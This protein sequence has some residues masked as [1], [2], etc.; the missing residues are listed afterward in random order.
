[1]NR[2][3]RVLGVLAMMSVL[4]VMGGKPAMA[5]DDH[6]SRGCQ[7]GRCY[8]HGE[9]HEGHDGRDWDDDH[10]GQS[11]YNNGQNNWGGCQYNGCYPRNDAYTQG[12][13]DG[14]RQGTVDGQQD[15]APRPGSY[16]RYSNAQDDYHRGYSEGYGAAYSQHCR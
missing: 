9:R 11:N 13:R 2:V 10:K 7:H 15:C 1:V 14:Y 4:L 6:D 16:D 12:Y 5:D 8:G 3:S